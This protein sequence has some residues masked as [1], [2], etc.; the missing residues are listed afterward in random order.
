MATG[1]KGICASKEDVV[2]RMQF[3]LLELQSKCLPRKGEIQ[4]P[5]DRMAWHARPPG[6]ASPH[7]GQKHWLFDTQGPG[8]PEVVFTG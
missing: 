4:N 3:I 8:S 1:S 5:Q 7:S 2:G 6:S